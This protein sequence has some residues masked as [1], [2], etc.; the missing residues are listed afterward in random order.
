MTEIIEY[1]RPIAGYLYCLFNEMYKYYG[2]NVKKCGNSENPEK[3]ALDYTTAYIE[4]CKIIKNSEK[5]VDKCFAETLLFYYLKEY[6]IKN[7]REFF[8][9]GDEIINKAFEQVDTFFKLYHTK[10]KIINHLLIRENYDKYYCKNT[11]KIVSDESI[12]DRTNDEDINVRQ[13]LDLNYEKFKEEHNK[14]SEKNK[15][16]YNQIDVLFWL[17][18]KLNIKRYEV[19]N[20]DKNI[21]IIN[22]KKILCE[23]I[24]LIFSIHTDGQNRTKK[25]INEKIIKIINKLDSYNKLQKYYVN[26]VN[27]ICDKTFKISF[28]KFNGGN[29]KLYNFTLL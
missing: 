6:R 13:L 25:F 10:E 22:F 14:N 16:I 9:C 28:T 5:Y 20:I 21:N 8:S 15:L 1:Y 12:S 11:C 27:N 7:N 23:N 26:C 24:L 29:S 3:R 19:N 18:K 4:P 17:E 2:E